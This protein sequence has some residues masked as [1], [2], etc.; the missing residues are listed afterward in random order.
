MSTWHHH[1]S[2]TTWHQHV[3]DVTMAPIRSGRSKYPDKPVS[4]ISMAFEQTRDIKHH[5]QDIFFGW[6]KYYQSTVGVLKILILIMIVVFEIP[7]VNNRDS[8]GHPWFRETLT[9]YDRR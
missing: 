2:D 1:S 4:N 6:D 5:D 9:L 7:K 8:I 3:C